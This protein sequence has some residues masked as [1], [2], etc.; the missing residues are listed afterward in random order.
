M[1][2]NEGKEGRL[3]LAVKKPSSLL[4]RIT[5]KHHGDFHCLNC[6]LSFATKKP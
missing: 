6:L 2:P 4:R 1:I 5:L 3:C